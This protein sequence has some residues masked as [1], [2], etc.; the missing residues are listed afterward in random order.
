MVEDNANHRTK[1]KFYKLLDNLIA[2]VRDANEEEGNEIYG[3]AREFEDR[4]VDLYG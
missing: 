2:E 4:F 1:T 3:H